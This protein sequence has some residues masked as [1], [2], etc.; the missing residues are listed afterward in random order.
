MFISNR[1]VPP[2]VTFPAAV[3]AVQGGVLSCSAKGTPPIY[4]A[5]IRD[6]TVLVN[7]TNTATIRL[8][9]DGNYTCRAIN[10]YGTDVDGLQVNFTSKEFFLHNLSFLVKYSTILESQSQVNF[11]KTPFNGPLGAKR[12]TLKVKYCYQRLS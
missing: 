1:L 4:T 5:L 3:L 9:K 10:Q 7:T 8:D 6:S 11:E 2:M 12:H